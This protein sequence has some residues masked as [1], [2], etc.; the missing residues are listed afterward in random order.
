MNG[1]WQRLYDMY[2]SQ[3]FQYLYYIVRNREICEK[4]IQDVYVKALCSST[5]FEGKTSEK[6]WLYSIAKD[7]GID[8]IRNERT[9]KS[10]WKLPHKSTRK[11]EYLVIDHTIYPEEILVQKEEMKRIYQSLLLC[12]EEEQQVIILRFIM[13]LSIAEAGDVLG[14][15]ERKV[16]AIGGRTINKIQ[17]KLGKQGSHPLEVISQ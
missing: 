17:K 10:W 12:T 1:K 13:G 9:K 2:H 5:S 7:V 11:L 3:L 16:R 6:T 8:W 15:S 14:W 4:L